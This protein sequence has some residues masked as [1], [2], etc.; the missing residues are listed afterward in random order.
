[1]EFHQN[2]KHLC[3]KGQYEQTERKTHR[4]GEKNLQIMIFKKLL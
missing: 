3:T 1:M 2:K 4:M